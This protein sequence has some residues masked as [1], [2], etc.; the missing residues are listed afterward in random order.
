MYEP[1]TGRAMASRTVEA[2]ENGSRVIVGCSPGRP[3]RVAFQEE[4]QKLLPGV[5]CEFKQVLGKTCSGPRNELIC[6][7]ESKSISK[8]PKPLTV[9]L[10]DLDPLIINH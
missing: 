7:Q 9:D 1:L 10:L 3:G 5:N 6:G 8:E 4:L 2:L